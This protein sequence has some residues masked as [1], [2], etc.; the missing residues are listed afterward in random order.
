M[1]WLLFQAYYIVKHLSY[2]FSPGK[3]LCP[4]FIDKKLKDRSRLPREMRLKSQ[5]EFQTRPSSCSMI[6]SFDLYTDLGRILPPNFCSCSFAL[7]QHKEEVV[8][9]ENVEFLGAC[10]VIQGRMAGI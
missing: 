8:L 6:S 9:I 3:V 7:S 5:T 1:S 4:H 10:S 2:P